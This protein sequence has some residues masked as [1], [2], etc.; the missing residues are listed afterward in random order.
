MGE[1]LGSFDLQSQA[2]VDPERL[3]WTR[4][5]AVHNDYLELAGDVGV[6]AAGLAVL[7]LLA[8]LGGAWRRTRAARGTSRAIQAGALG[9]VVGVLAHS[10]VDFPL[11]QPGIALLLLVALAVALGPGPYQRRPRRPLRFALGAWGLLLLCA[12]G[13]VAWRGAGEASGREAYAKIRGVRAAL[14]GEQTRRVLPVLRGGVGFGARGEGA[15]LLGSALETQSVYLMSDS[16]RELSAQAHEEALGQLR[17]AVQK[18]PGDA[19]YQLQLAAALLRSPATPERQ[20]EVARRLQIALERTPT[21]PTVLFGGA[22][23]ALELRVRSGDEAHLA[24][25]ER[26]LRRGLLQRPDEARR[27]RAIAKRY[28]AKLGRRADL[29]LERIAEF[30]AAG[31]ASAQAREAGP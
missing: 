30:E 18:S 24:L 26:C 28:A 12:G 6:P 19:R 15:A 21:Q 10:A 14:R 1:G 16:E 23:V 31:K 8:L 17:L 13:L 29:L 22:E 9:G 11:H 27:A 25:A 20:L 5:G 4:P 3:R 7:G 2:R